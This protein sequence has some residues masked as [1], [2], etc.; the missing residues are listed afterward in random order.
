MGTLETASLM[1]PREVAAALRCSQSSVY[2][3]IASGELAA[4]RV[5]PGALRVSADDLAAYLLRVNGDA[6]EIAGGDAS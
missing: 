5:G 4:I 2:A 1:K 3:R 6:S